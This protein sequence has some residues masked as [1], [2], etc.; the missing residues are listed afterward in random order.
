MDNPP[1]AEQIRDSF[2]LPCDPVTKKS[3]AVT[4]GLLPTLYVWMV[5]E[6]D[7]LPEA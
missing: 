1:L 5:R 3:T 4:L 7:I 2:L 6:E